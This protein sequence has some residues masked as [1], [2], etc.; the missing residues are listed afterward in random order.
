MTNERWVSD[1]EAAL[2]GIGKL[3]EIDKLALQV[4]ARA[5]AIKQADPIMGARIHAAFEAARQRLR[6][7]A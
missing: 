7:G 4:S 3:A 1:I 6:A 5:L 2:D